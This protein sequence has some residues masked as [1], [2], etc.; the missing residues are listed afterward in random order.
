MC[1]LP[2]SGRKNACVGG[3]WPSW[4]ERT[5]PGFDVSRLREEI[6]CAARYGTLPTEEPFREGNVGISF[7][8]RRDGRIRAGKGDWDKGGNTQDLVDAGWDAC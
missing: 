4:K 1:L 2:D 3:L 7:A 8:G 5:D 6:Q